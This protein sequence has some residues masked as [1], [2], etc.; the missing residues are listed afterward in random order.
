[1]MLIVSDGFADWAGGGKGV[2]HEADGCRVRMRRPGQDGAALRHF[3]L[4]AGGGHGG[5]GR[6]RG[7]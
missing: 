4:D 7:V 2:I 1:M 5:E 6:V 3:I